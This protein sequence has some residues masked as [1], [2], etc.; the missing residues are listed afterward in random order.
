VNSIDSLGSSIQVIK[1]VNLNGTFSG[2]SFVTFGIPLRGKMKGSNLNFNNS[3][4]FNRN[5]S[6][7]YGELNMSRT[8]VIT[9]TAGVNLVF[10]DKL[11][12]GLNGSVAYNDVRYTVQQNMN[13]TYFSQTYTAD[14]SY[15]LIKDWVLY[16]DYS[17]YI[18]SGRSEGYNET[19]PLWN[20]SLAREIFKKKNGEIKISVNDILNQNKSITRTVGDNYILDSKSNV[21]MRYFM[22]T[23]TYNLNRAGIN[24]RNQ[25][26]PRG[27]PRNIQ[28]EM[29]QLKSDQSTT[30]GSPPEPKK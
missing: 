17:Q 2:T 6:L 18:I 14:I 26:A 20:A 4:A 25:G 15:I 30:P 13:N 12:L 10:N 8:W 11:N 3:I 7:L 29:D 27:V 21:L 22:L 5:P 23:F 9:Q 1:P 28:R 24:N 16:T 19:I